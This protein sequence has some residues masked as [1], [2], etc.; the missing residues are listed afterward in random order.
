MTLIVFLRIISDLGLYGTFAGVAA[1]LLGARPPVMTVGLLLLSLIVTVSFA[2]RER[3]RL[4]FLPLVL[5]AFCWLF[6]AQKFM[7]KAYF[8][9][10][11]FYA[12]SIVR[13][14]QYL[15]TWERQS[16]LF[17]MYWKLAAAFLFIGEVFSSLIAG[18]GALIDA[19]AVPAALVTCSAQ[20]LLLRS[21][22]HDRDVYTQR[23]HQLVDLT[24]FLLMLVAAG[25]LTSR[26]M[27]SAYGAVFTLIFRCFLLPVGRVLL[28][29]LELFIRLI[30]WVMSKFF[31]EDIPLALPDLSDMGVEMG[32]E[33]AAPVGT[34]DEGGSPLFAA[35]LLFL[36]AAMVGTLLYLLFRRLTQQTTVAE[37]QGARTE[38]RVR[39]SL[40]G[41]QT[42]PF[43]RPITPVQRIRHQYRRYLQLCR[44][45]GLPI[46]PRHTTRHIADMSA[47][48]M[49]PEAVQ[50]LR[51]LYLSARYNDTGEK[52]D[53]DQAE[54]A[55][56]RLRESARR[57]Q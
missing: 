48:T 19:V 2:L 38:E 25:A 15:P 49:D 31:R 23:R 13:S 11:L 5:A 1:G 43:L 8:L 54:A 44:Q 28:R 26:P 34:P 21:L 56:K 57:G 10:L 16:A 52:A 22:R 24:L 36:I 47:N 42:R 6:A 45:R 37:E 50:K 9:P 51:Q 18:D 14:G 29:F 53:A 17:S 3:G 33:P 20:L 7:E 41:E 30:S 40:P 55:Y 4:R 12:I 32:D 39:I 35:L 46:R 27:L